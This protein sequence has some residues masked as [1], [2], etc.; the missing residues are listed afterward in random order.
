MMQLPDIYRNLVDIAPVSKS[1]ELLVAVSGGVDSVVLAHLCYRAGLR[2][3]LVHCNFN[4]RGE[5]SD[6]DELL[7][8]NVGESWSKEVLVKSFD[9]S[10]YAAEQKIS[11][12]E[13]ARQLRYEWFDELM[14]VQPRF[15]WLLT[16]HHSDDNIETL[17]MNFFRGTGI[18]GLTGIPPKNGKILRPLL[19]LNRQY[20]MQWAIA[21]ELPFVEDSSN[22]KEDYTRNYFRL[23]VLPSIE[24]VYP[25]VAKNL[26]NN[27]KRFSGIEKFYQESVHKVL[28]RIL[29][30]KGEEIHIPIGQ[31]RRYQH[32]SLLYEMLTPY[33]FSTG[34]IE[35]AWQLL[36]AQSGA[37]INAA[38]QSWRLIRH[39]NW[40]ILAPI[41]K[42]TST[43]S[44][45][46]PTAT[47]HLFN[48]GIL[49]LEEITEGLDKI[50]T[51]NY[52]I[53]LDKKNI[54]FPLL[55]R[56]WKEGDYFYPLGMAKK[57]KIARFLIDQRKTTTQKEKIWV[58]ETGERICWVVGERIDDRFKVN[59]STKS[60][61]SIRLQRKK[62]D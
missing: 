14:A 8:R 45:I 23:T 27:I 25:E 57:K 46:Q 49:T 39:R 11:I 9:T 35:E 44:L 32:T 58:L 18:A 60:V 56:P 53:W 4:L 37:C 15:K 41:K 20:L 3:T 5:E 12:Q 1:D 30:P 7:V 38:M 29:Q 42:E 54:Q 62:A 16:A 17:V 6:R 50:P 26:L 48:E 36:S 22:L 24:K 10:Q 34:Q 52:H 43:Y 51:D 19:P 2:I 47:Q 13:A 55:L 21:N 33:G 40:L 28:S 59:S 61:L 31:L